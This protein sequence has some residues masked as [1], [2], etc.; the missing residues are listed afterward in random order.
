MNGTTGCPK[1]NSPV[2]YIANNRTGEIVCCEET[3]TRGLTKAGR[4]LE[5]FKIHECGE[6]S[7]SE[8]RKLIGG[9]VIIEPN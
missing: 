5:I 4:E 3:T 8:V 1:C 2:K 6:I 9:G 7:I